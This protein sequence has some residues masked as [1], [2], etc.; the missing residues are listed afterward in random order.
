MTPS[1]WN[2]LG[3]C[4]MMKGDYDEADKIFPACGW[5]M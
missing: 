3:V 4:Y 2:F 5:K 1:S